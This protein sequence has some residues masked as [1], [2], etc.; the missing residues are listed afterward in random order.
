MAVSLEDA[1]NLAQ[2]LG[3]YGKAQGARS[4]LEIFLTAVPFGALWAVM[5]AALGVNYWLCLLLAIPTAG[6]LVRLFMIQHDCGHGAFFRRRAT[7]DWV[8]R[9]IGVLTLTPYGFWRRTHA[10]HHA[11]VG[12][13]EHR[14]IG[15]IDT[16]TVSEYLAR[17]RAGRLAYRIYRHPIVMFGIIPPYLFLLHY[18]FPA[19]LMR[20]GRQPWLSTMGTNAA[21]AAVVAMMAWLVGIRPFLLLDAPVVLL[22]AMLGMWFFYVQ[23]QFEHTEW[24]HDKAWNFYAVALHGSSYYELPRILAW[25]SGN[26][27]VHHVHHLCSRIPFYRLPRV[28]NDH[29]ELASVGRLT[30]IQSL[31]CASLA[32]WDEGQKRL[33]SFRELRLRAAEPTLA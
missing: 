22:A 23:H 31:R 5:W 1:R 20:A 14:G 26:I 29:P 16:L 33:I 6:F 18:R 11:A 24:A 28:L 4:W 10:A 2:Q 30:L 19:G 32:L 3:R 27:G 15:D 17:S 25:F 7:N 12:N 9:I 21:I 13:L 8:G